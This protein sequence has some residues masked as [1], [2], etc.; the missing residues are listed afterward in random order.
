M[1]RVIFII[2]QIIIRAYCTA[3][4]LNYAHPIQIQVSK[5]GFK[6]NIRTRR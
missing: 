3:S 1:R 6:D 4:S 5:R 2:Q